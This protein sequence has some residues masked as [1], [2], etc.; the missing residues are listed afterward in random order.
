[1]KK[2]YIL[3]FIFCLLTICKTIYAQIHI[4]VNADKKIATVSKL[5]NGTNI[6]DLN[7]QTNGGLFSQLLHGEAFEENVDIDFL[8]VKRADYSK[9]Y[10][11]LDERRI[12]HLITQSDI[13]HKVNWNHLSD[14]YDFYTK[15]VY[16]CTRFNNP[17]TISGLT[18]YGRVLPFDSLSTTIQQAM[19]DKINGNEQISKYWSKAINGN[20]TYSYKLIRDGKAYIGRQTQQVNYIDGTGEVG[21]SNSGLYR[22][23]ICYEKGKNYEGIVRV[24]SHEPLTFYVSLRDGNGK[25]LDE[26]PC[27]LKGDGSY[28]KA[29]F[30]LTPKAHAA[31]GSFCIA[32]KQPG[33]LNLGFAFLQPGEWGRANGYP[34]RKP[35][36]DALKRQG[37]TAIRYNGSM[38]D[39]GA[40][41]HLYRWKKMLAPID[42]RRTLFRSG[43]NM[44]ATHSFG[45][46]EM[47]KAA[48][49]LQATAIIG[50]SQDETAED[51]RD[52]VEYVNGPQDSPWGF[53]RARDGHA[54]PYQLKYIEVDNEQRISQG[55]VE[56]VKKFAESAWSVDPDMNIMVSLNIKK[57]RF[58]RNTPNY[59]LASELVGWF[60]RQGKGDKLAWDSHYSGDLDFA[61]DRK[62]LECEMGI[63]LQQELAKDYP[64]FKLHLTPLEEN[65]SRCDWNRG[66][67]H[68]H[69][70]IVLQRYGNHFEMLGTANTF[71]PH[72]LH[73]M[74]DQGRIHYTAD[75]IW[76]QPSAYIDKLMMESWKP[77]VVETTSSEPQKIDLTAKINEK[78]DELT[79]YV[80]NLTDQPQ[81]A[82][83]GINNFVSKGKAE[84]VTLGDCAL[85][86]YNTA[87]KQ[88]NVVPRYS[89]QNIKGETAYTFPKYSYTMITLHKTHTVI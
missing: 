39:V 70:W 48:E 3:S 55:Y 7:N 52:F 50:M 28:E 2:K 15:D 25:I 19:L 1:M 24:M 80:V 36:I 58:D 43:F 64:G 35:F 73:Y 60:I 11:I 71:Q 37:I 46:I 23:G 87:D 77:Y 29:T 81:E 54:A 10:V 20:P 76:F 59:K 33:T 4:E 68:A 61:C 21:I 14:K 38:V 30:S 67:A 79:L 34:L 65:G 17:K 31:Q 42:E 16:G 63:E 18:F 13:Y 6:E 78:G 72:G 86:E 56:C 12:P 8:N 57:G 41:K 66:L 75:R 47:L 74:W 89:R 32:L 62:R 82:I 44:Y 26:K 84:I 83:I 49:C 85:T 45:I 22:M 9:L 69:N 51:I 40:D 88:D 27:T 53:K 5:F